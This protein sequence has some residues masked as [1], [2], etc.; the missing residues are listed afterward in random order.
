M[1]LAAICGLD[2]APVQLTKSSNKDVLLIER[3]DRR[4]TDAGW[5]RRSML[6]ALTLL[7]LDEMMARYASYEDF[8]EL[9]RHKFTDV[10]ETLKELFSRLVFNVCFKGDSNGAK[11]VRQLCVLRSKR[12]DGG[13]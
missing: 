10:S 8:A 1:R 9:I 6:S 2:V 13:K 5:Q 11:E 4:H 12:A 3:F 7:G